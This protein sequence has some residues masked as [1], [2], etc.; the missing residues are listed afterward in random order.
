MTRAWTIVPVI[1]KNARATQHH[2]RSSRRN[3][4][5]RVGLLGTDV[6]G[7]TA[8]GGVWPG[9][10]GGS[11]L[12]EFSGASAFMTRRLRLNCVV[13][14]QHYLCGG[15]RGRSALGHFE[16]HVLGGIDAGEAGGAETACAIVHGTAK[17][18]EREIAH[19]IRS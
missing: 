14:F 1:K 7:G 4:L 15:F 16:L 13:L 6:A 11:V 3:R 2:E 19:R 8:S 18:I 5:P 12:I 10:S 9:S 17:A